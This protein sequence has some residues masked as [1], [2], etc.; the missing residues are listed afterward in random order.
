MRRCRFC[1]RQRRNIKVQ[2]QESGELDEYNN[3]V[4]QYIHWKES[5]GHLKFLDA[6]AHQ[7]LKIPSA[8][9]HH[10]MYGQTCQ[11]YL[12]KYIIKNGNSDI[13]NRYFYNGKI[14]K[15]RNGDY[16]LEVPAP[17][18]PDIPSFNKITENTT[19]NDLYN[20]NYLL[21]LN[22]E[23]I[24]NRKNEWDIFNSYDEIIELSNNDISD[25]HYTDELYEIEKELGLS[26][27]NKYLPKYVYQSKVYPN[28]RV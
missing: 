20:K 2:V 3:Y 19:L 4:D 17:I 15:G 21:H 18:P 13:T 6:N 1:Q 26:G 14:V 7:P 22:E 9:Y 11:S 16:K 25:E 5:Y 10:Q 28:F 8:M 24:E 23:Y 27:Y 12:V